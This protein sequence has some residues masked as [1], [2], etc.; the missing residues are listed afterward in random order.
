VSPI[1][2]AVQVGDLVVVEWL[3]QPYYAENGAV[4]NSIVCV[5]EFMLVL[6]TDRDEVRV[7]SSSGRVGWIDSD[8]IEGVP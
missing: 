5:D 2:G 4:T 7:V 8:N 1:E 3:T 6:Q